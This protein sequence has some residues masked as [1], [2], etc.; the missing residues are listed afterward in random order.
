MIRP[1]LLRTAASVRA[2]FFGKAGGKKALR[3]S[4]VDRKAPLMG[5]HGSSQDNPVKSHFRD[6]SLPERLWQT[7]THTHTHTHTQ[8]HTHTVEMENKS[9]LHS[10]AFIV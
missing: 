2:A 10:A 7:W 6:P 4:L 1:H 8:M 9:L 3:S 5:T